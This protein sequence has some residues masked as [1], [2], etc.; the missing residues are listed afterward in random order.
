MRNAEETNNLAKGKEGENIAVAFLKNEGYNIIERNFRS[1]FGEIDIVASY[2]SFIIF[3]EVKA[4]KNFSFG[5]PEESVNFIKQEHIK[6]TAEY[7]LYKNNEKGL[8][9]RIDIISVDLKK[10][11]VV[12]HIRN[13]F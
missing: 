5:R 12:N 10:K 11:E 13:A 3:V 4:R 7:Y 1:P 6:K 2:D 9:C 8:C